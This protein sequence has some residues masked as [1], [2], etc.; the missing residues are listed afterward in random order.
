MEPDMPDTPYFFHDLA[1]DQYGTADDRPPLVF[2][3]SL[4]YDRQQWEPTVDALALTDA[5]RQV[6]VLDLPGH[7]NSPARPTY[8]LDEVTDAV[9]QAVTAAGL[10]APVLVGHGLGAALATGY[11]AAYPSRGVVNVD[12]P[13]RV[14][15]FAEV[16]RRFE[17]VLRG[18]DYAQVW[19]SLLAGMQIDLLPVEAQD[20]VQTM[21][22]PRQDLLLGYWDELLTHPAEECTARWTRALERIG[23]AGYHYVSGTDPDPVYRQ[24]LV[25]S[26][27][28]VMITVL[29][30]SGHFTHLAR[31]FD[32][33][34]ILAG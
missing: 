21:S 2:L 27:P 24:W 22:V 3:H 33:A 10:T 18:R 4:G 28:D 23:P 20:L 17:P 29:P 34:K 9:H 30:G 8:H 25:A 6:L 1:G 15:G 7:G 16:L 26:R 31:P 14:E 12:Q 11:A 19:T 13:L 32:L 5:G